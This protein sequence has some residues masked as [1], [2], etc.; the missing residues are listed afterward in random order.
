MAKSME[1]L[2]KGKEIKKVDPCGPWDGV[3]CGYETFMEMVPMEQS[4][5]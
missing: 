1:M 2:Y 3:I 5:P 4:K